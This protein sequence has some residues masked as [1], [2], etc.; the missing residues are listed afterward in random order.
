MILGEMQ[1]Y[2]SQPVTSQNGPE[3]R[4]SVRYKSSD[5][6]SNSSNFVDREPRLKETVEEFG[7]QTAGSGIRYLVPKQHPGDL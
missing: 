7:S 6:F 4:Y 3:G 1:Y 5:M 2:C